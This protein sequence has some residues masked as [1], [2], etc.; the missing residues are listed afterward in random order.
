MDWR[1]H[2]DSRRISASEAV[3]KIKSG[4]R[5]VVGHA[6]GEPS[7]VID[8]MVANCQAYHD[9]EIVHMVFMGKGEYCKSGMEKHFRHNSLFVGGSAREAIADGRADYTP[10]YFSEIP[11][12]F[13]NGAL[14]PDVALIHV[15][16]PDHTGFCSFGVSV[17]YTSTAARHAKLVIA[18][19]NK[20]MPRTLGDS[21]I[22]VSEIDV[23]VEH[24]APLIEL[25]PPVITAVEEKIGQ[26]CAE[27]IQDGD[28]LQLGIGSLPDAV[29]H[30][31]THKKDLGI[32]SEMISDGVV[33]LVE[34]DV[35]TNMKKTLHRGKMVVSF[36]MGTPKLYEFV[37]DNPMVY[38][39]PVNYVNDPYV[40][41]QN[42]NMISI[43]SCVQVDLMGQVCSESI[44]LKQISAVGGQVDFVRGANMSRGGKSIIAMP[45][46]AGGGKISKIVALLDTGAAVTTNRNDVSFIVTEYG[47]AC[48][49]GKTLRERAKA[50]IGIAHPDFR[51]ALQEEYEK[52]FR[53]SFE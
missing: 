5:I 4:D 35:I 20:Y 53:R 18:Q 51:P 7:H 41:R 24:D 37:H 30:A 15:S 25:A 17:D 10:C 27:L 21:F 38:M 26:N 40:I 36:L 32:H 3:K 31:L 23:F 44:G 16:A 13:T 22:H 11:S 33:K 50:L 8:A 46:T 34:E 39:A 12:L 29:L 42:D 6:V 28:T 45:S 48:L 52:R 43:N 2:Y 9:V 14:P 1:Q 47:H 49:K 19:V